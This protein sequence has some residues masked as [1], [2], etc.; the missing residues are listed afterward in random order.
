MK[1]LLFALLFATGIASAQVV[2]VDTTLTTDTPN[3]GRIKY[4]NSLIRLQNSLYG[5]TVDTSGLSAMRRPI[6]VL[7][8]DTV[9]VAKEGVM[10]GADTN[11]VLS[12]VRAD[13]IGRFARENQVLVA[14]TDPFIT[15]SNLPNLGK[16]GVFSGADGTTLWYGNLGKSSAG[17][18]VY[19]YAYG[20]SQLRYRTSSDNGKTWSDFGIVV[21]A[22]TSH[23]F[24]QC[25]FGITPTGA[26]VFLGR[27][28]T[29]VSQTK[30]VRIKSVRSTNSGAS[31]TVT[32]TI[33]TIMSAGITSGVK[34]LSDGT[35]IAAFSE[36]CFGYASLDALY[37]V[38]NHD[39]TYV[40]VIKSTDD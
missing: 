37:G 8:G 5:R 39:T 4:N 27:E 24:E 11:D 6:L 12:L 30:C 18:L 3:Q 19:G 35:L 25:S 15:G 23:T 2:R 21:S 33:A 40:R 28:D 34:S 10:V 38:S 36:G 22:S 20:G 16:K 29:L 26:W 17:V 31:W 13:S 9:W 7:Q 1:R 14:P 32:D